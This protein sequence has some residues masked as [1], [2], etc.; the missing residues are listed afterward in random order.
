MYKIR[1]AREEDREEVVKLLTRTFKEIDSFKNYWIEN[2]R[3][4][5]NRPENYDWAFIATYDEKIIANLSY[6]LSNHDKIRGNP[7][8]FG[9]VWAVA[10]EKNHRRQGILKGIYERVFPDMNK[11]GIAVSILDPSP[12]PFAQMAYERMGYALAERRVKH[13]F[14]P[15]SMK[16]SDGLSD[17]TLKEI[18]DPNINIKIAE[19][20]SKM[21]RY[22]SRV[23]TFPFFFSQGIKSGNFYMLERNSDPVG[24]VRLI[25]ENN[26]VDTVLKVENAYFITD[27]I[28]PFM[29][30]LISRK[31]PKVT[32]IEWICDPQIPIRLFSRNIKRIE[33]QN[34][35]SMLM[36]VVNF[37]KYCESIR[38]PEDIEATLTIKLSDDLCQWNNGVYNLSLS[39][40]MLNVEKIDNKYETDIALD[41]HGLSNVI[42]GYMHPSELRKYG[43]ISCSHDIA[44]KLD[45]IFPI[46][47]FQSYYRF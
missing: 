46:D 9:G 21:S 6:F 22:G 15:N 7:I 23:F 14:S 3:N 45:S 4:Y 37:E 10:T 30:E 43:I 40:G 1:E 13:S 11:H 35:E 19:L 34:V 5:W 47:S 27:D 20:E 2:W 25:S 36:R 17:I 39:E 18:K 44:L 31:F 26:D 16:L 8:F 28:V 29:I 24:C 12:Y 38:P 42:S 32:K 41:P 33:T